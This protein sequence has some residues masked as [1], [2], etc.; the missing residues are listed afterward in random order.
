MKGV[1]ATRAPGIPIV[2]VTHDVPPQGIALGA[3]LLAT[4]APYFP[5]GTVHVAVVDP[6]VG[7]E[8]AGA[9]D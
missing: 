5:P 9:T 8:P 6:G 7:S 2:D 1:I 3:F 4:A